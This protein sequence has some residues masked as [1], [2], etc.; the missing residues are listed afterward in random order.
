VQQNIFLITS[1]TSLHFKTSTVAKRTTLSGTEM[2]AY[3]L[4]LCRWNLGK[5]IY[6]SLATSVKYL[7]QF[8]L[9]KV[10]KFYDHLQLA[11]VLASDVQQL[12]PEQFF[13][14]D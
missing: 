2:T 1:V 12:D 9:I 10:A 11:A 5:P 6:C 13:F 8:I 14:D 3:T 4:M 7:N